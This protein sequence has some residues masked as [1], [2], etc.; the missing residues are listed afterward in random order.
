MK[1]TIALVALA[2]LSGA[3][4]AQLS[5]P[6]SLPGQNGTV[7]ILQAPSVAVPMQPLRPGLQQQPTPPPADP[8]GQTH[9][10]PTGTNE[11]RP[12]EKKLPAN[13]AAQASTGKKLKFRSTPTEN[14]FEASS[15]A[16]PRIDVVRVNQSA[17]ERFQNLRDDNEGMGQF[18]LNTETSKYAPQ[19]Q[20]ATAQTSQRASVGKMVQSKTLMGQPAPPDLNAKSDGRMTAKMNQD[21]WCERFAN[22]EPRVL[23]V[24]VDADKLTP[25][26]SFVLKGVCLGGKPGLIDVRLQG[27]SNKVYRANVQNWEHGKILATLPENIEG[28]PPTIAEITVTTAGNRVAKPGYFSFEPKWELATVLHHFTRVVACAAD[29]RYPYTRSRCLAEKGS[30]QS[31]Q[32]AVPSSCRGTCIYWFSGDN[33]GKIDPNRD[34]EFRS[35]RY[36]EEDLTIESERGTDRWTFDLPPYAILKSWRVTQESFDNTKNTVRTAW[37]PATQQIVAHWTMGEIGEQGYLSYSVFDA[38]AWF[39]VGMPQKRVPIP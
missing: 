25:G 28:V 3:A 38:K 23:R 11:T 9:G 32:F 10:A 1:T 22:H 8:S 39:P 17:R 18:E 34:G 19:Q 12:V 5:A 14:T 13:L 30:Y 21:V 29:Q 6:S 31:Q 4:L 20:S 2:S 33:S 37:D 7:P 24:L 35:I 15:G 16:P 26:M 27:E 36:T